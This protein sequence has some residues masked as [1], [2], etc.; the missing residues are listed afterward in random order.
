MKIAGWWGGEGL[1]DGGIDNKHK[2]F[3]W[4]LVTK[5]PFLNRRTTEQMEP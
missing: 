2:S 5:Q 1:E 4:F 3:P